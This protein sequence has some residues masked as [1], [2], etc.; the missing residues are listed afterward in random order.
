MQIFLQKRI[1]YI[2]ILF[3]SLTLISGCT[4]S[5][6]MEREART[7]AQLQQDLRKQQSYQIALKETNKQRNQERSRLMYD[8]T[9]AEK[10]IADL[11]AK[12][13]RLS[14]Q[15]RAANSQFNNINSK[16]NTLDAKISNLNNKISHAEQQQQYLQ[17]QYHEEK[18]KL[19]EQARSEVQRES[20]LSALALRTG[21]GAGKREAERKKL[22]NTT[23]SLENN[24]VHLEKK[25][26]ELDRELAGLKEEKELRLA[27]K[28]KIESDSTRQSNR[29]RGN[30]KS[31]DEIDRLSKEKEKL[32]R[33]VEQK[34]KTLKEY[35]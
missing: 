32:S 18:R 5:R 27:E 9:I 28:R 20:S 25:M 24:K 10:K 14:Q 7:T 29:I 35:L 19:E 23:S 15:S 13:S 34:K 1:Y 16:V 2:P 30:N 8:I 11:D 33:T 17:K 3:S 12:I 6:A 31:K 26:H 22:A 21:R 4:Y